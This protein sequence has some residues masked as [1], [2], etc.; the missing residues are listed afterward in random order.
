MTKEEFEI[1]FRKRQNRFIW[2]FALTLLAVPM[3]FINPGVAIF[4]GI[5]NLFYSIFLNLSARSNANDWYCANYEKYLGTTEVDFDNLNFQN[6][7]EDSE[8]T[9]F[10]FEDDSID[11][12]DSVDSHFENNKAV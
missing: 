11:I 12:T 4:F 5:V 8:K 9:E 7:S 3:Y 10:Y 1:A 2:L 6:E